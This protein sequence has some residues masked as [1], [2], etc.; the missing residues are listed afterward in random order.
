MMM[1]TSESLAH[2]E[3]RHAPRPRQELHGLLWALQYVS[4]A[5]VRELRLLAGVAVDGGGVHVGWVL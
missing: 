2:F 3:R 1:V 5:R 4:S